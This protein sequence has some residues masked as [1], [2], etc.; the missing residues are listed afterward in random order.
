MRNRL[1]L[2]RDHVNFLKELGIL[3]LL[4]LFFTKLCYLLMEFISLFDGFIH[5]IFE[6]VVHLGL[7]LVYLDLLSNT[8]SQELV[9]LLT[10]V[11]YIR[12]KT[13]GS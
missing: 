13:L 6:R 11:C 4:L 9:S 12:S 1:K 8:R 7:L 3:G 10:F 5:L 2:A